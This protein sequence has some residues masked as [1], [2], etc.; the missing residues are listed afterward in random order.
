MMGY[1]I[2]AVWSMISF[3][4]LLS[5][6]M[7]VKLPNHHIDDDINRVL[8]SGYHCNELNVERQWLRPEHYLL[9]DSELVSAA[10]LEQALQAQQEYAQ[11]CPPPLS[12]NE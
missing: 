5:A 8:A 9:N 3:V 10:Q 2:I 1:K 11:V 4:L 12:G 6:I 7:T